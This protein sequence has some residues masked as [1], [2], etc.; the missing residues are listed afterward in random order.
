MS[1]L[2]GNSSGASQ[3]NL[4][5]V[6][7]ENVGQIGYYHAD[8]SMRFVVNANERARID[9][10]GNLLVGKTASDGTTIGAE[11]R[12]SGI[13][14]STVSG[15]VCGNFNR[16]TSDGT[17]LNFQKDGSTVGSIG[18][19]GGRLNIGS[20][21][22]H[23][24]FDSGDSPSIR[25][26]NGSSATDGVID[27]GESGTRFKDLYLSGAAYTGGQLKGSAGSATKLI[28]NAT[29]TTTEVHASGTTGIVFK[30]N[31]DGE[32][33][34][35]DSSG[36]VGIGTTSPS[37]YYATELVLSAP[38]EGGMT[39]VASAANANNYILF[40]DGTSGNAAYRGQLN[41]NHSDDGL[42]LV[43]SGYVTL[44]SGEGRAE[45]MRI[46]SSGNAL[47]GC[48]AL[49]SG[50]AG[51]AAFETGQ[52]SGRSILQLGTT[53]TSALRVT[54]FYNGNGNVGNITL[55]G[56]ATAYNTSSDARLKDVTGKARG[57]EV[58]NELNPVAYNWK[59][60]GKADEGLIA[61][62][63]KELVPNAVSGSEEEM[64]QM[65]YSKLVV[66]LVAGMKEQQDTITELTARLEALE[67]A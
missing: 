19:N 46:D 25:P 37:S 8:N 36:N 58:I 51:G 9:S 6:N 10:S 67:N 53:S 49:P 7:D 31:G 33:A 3:I 11:L 18:T 54:N 5:D 65:D 56:S 24:F 28:L 55:S 16:K 52:S 23:I 42:N 48:T 20:D 64:Y 43:S 17:I 63:V 32:T 27:I 14:T 66:H 41:Y 12:S 2:G 61:Q 47:F 15:N 40:A 26:H 21:D 29:S 39:M 50:G 13:I 34:R 44:R 30:N 59:A 38:N 60:D 62:E 57:L 45:A 22:T 35:I 4:G 1:I